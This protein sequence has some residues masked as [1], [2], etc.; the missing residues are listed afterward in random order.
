MS[1][2]GTEL[3][4][5][6]LGAFGQLAARYLAP[7]FTI[8]AYDPAPDAASRAASLGIEAAPIEQAAAAPVVVLAMPVQALEDVCARIAP[9]LRPGALVLDVCSVKIRPM[10]TMRE[11]LP[12]H[13]RVLGTHPLFGPQSARDGV[14]GHQIVLCPDR[15]ADAD[16]VREFLTEKLGLRVSIATP[17]EHDRAMAVVQGLTHLVAK[18]LLRVNAEPPPFTTDSFDLMMRSAG[19]LRHDSEQLFRAIEQMNPYAGAVRREF[20]AAARKLDESL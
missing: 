12:A 20:F 6:G 11:L 18:V 10:Q 3:G 2:T 1:E 7:H 15:S 5:I 4:L 17:D 9:M 19:L 14:A 13:V 16:C 8:R